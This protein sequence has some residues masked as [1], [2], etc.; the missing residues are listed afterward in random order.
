MA[1]RESAELSLVL[2]VAV[3][4]MGVMVAAPLKLVVPQFRSM[5]ARIDR[6]N[7]VLREQIT[8]STHGPSPAPSASSRSSMPPRRWSIPLRR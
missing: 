7:R 1:V 6:I 2:L 8:S 4:L 3:P 5:Q